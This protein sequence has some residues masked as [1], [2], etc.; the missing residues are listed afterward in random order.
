GGRLGLR[1]PGEDRRAGER[2]AVDIRSASRVLRLPAG[3]LGDEKTILIGPEPKRPTAMA[4]FAQEDDRW[5]LTL[6]GYGGHHPPG[7]PDG[8]LAFARIIAPAHILAAIRPAGP[9]G[10]IPAHRFPANLRRRDDLR[11]Q[12]PARLPGLRGGVGR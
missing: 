2:L 1:G 8:F 7:E 4:L 11:G 5:I 3:A 9:L 12:F 10:D 6:A